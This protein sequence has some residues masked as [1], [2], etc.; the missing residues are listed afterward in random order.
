[1]VYQLKF[2]GDRGAGRQQGRVGFVPLGVEVV[3]EL[4]GAKLICLH[5]KPRLSAHPDGVI[6]DPP[7]SALNRGYVSF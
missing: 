1:M 6:M 7:P 2:E 4:G 5:E 3:P